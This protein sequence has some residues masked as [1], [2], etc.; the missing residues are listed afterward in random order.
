LSCTSS[1]AYFLIPPVSKNNMADMWTC[2]AELTRVSL[3]AEP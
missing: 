2:E 3:S 1:Y